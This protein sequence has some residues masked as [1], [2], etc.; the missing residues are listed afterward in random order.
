MVFFI[1]FFLYV[2]L[3]INPALYY[4]RQDPIFLLDYQ[5]FRE[6]LAYPG[7]L[8]E[9]TGAFLSQFY[10]FSIWGALIVTASAWAVT[11]LTAAL[12]RA[13]R[14]GSQIQV[15]HYIPAI[16]LLMLHGHYTHSLTINL[17]LILS[18]LFTVAY[19]RLKKE[20]HL[21]IALYLGFGLILYYL[22]AGYYVLFA[23]MCALYEIL[24][25]RR[26]LISALYVVIAAV[27]PYLAKETLFLINYRMAYLGLL[28][29]DES[30]TPIYTPYGLII[31]FILLVVL[32]HPL[33]VERLNF[34]RKIKFRK[35]WV[36]YALQTLLVFA[37][38]GYAAII[39]FEK[40]NNLLLQVD[41]YAR[42]RQWQEILKISAQEKSNLLQVAFH[43]NRA[44]FHTD[45][46][47]DGMFSFSQENGT[48]GLMLPMKYAESAL[49]QESDFCYDLGSINES[50]HWAY[51]AVTIDGETPW[52][53]Q[54]MVIVN[55]LSGDLRAAERCLNELD[56]T[57]FFKSWREDFR[58]KLQNP[59]QVSD[60]ETLKHGR[61]MLMNTDYLIVSGHPPVE[62][63]SLLK[64]NPHNKMAFEYKI[65]QELLTCRLGGLPG[66]LTMLNNFGY[67]HIPT[68]M[69]EA[70]LSMWLMSRT[71]E[72]PP[73]L[74][75]IRH[76]TFQRFQEFNKVLSKYRGDR[77][78]A[79]R[80]LWQWFG[81]T[82][83]YY[84]FYYNPIERMAGP[85]SSRKGGLE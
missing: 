79:R 11:R 33:I 44:L 13:I 57:L 49:L 19:F 24:H 77:K 74:R 70:L 60:D 10:F 58:K 20:N 84:L 27:I 69:E 35:S 51:E 25:L 65:A 18:L 3:R 52:I 55:Y 45:Q 85:T 43:T 34:L 81:N 39:T 50:R 2:W 30:Y 56:K 16:L 67:Q 14:P 63:D 82:Y 38:A 47:L 54:R 68:H 32:C 76:E 53:L 8:L 75:Y 80:E 62:L 5:F 21:R 42:H 64:K 26:P 1:G 31:F 78:A 36:W 66:D 61:S 6:F 15:V 22:A 59:A 17:G 9:Y 71:K 29:F 73:A 40:N 12:I 83:W 4:Q 23:L 37:I 46:L 48:A 7:G 28:P 41:Y 72:I